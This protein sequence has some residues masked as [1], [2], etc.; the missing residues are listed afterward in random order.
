M[1]TSSFVVPS[2]R[3]DV[4]AM[5]MRSGCT[6]HHTAGSSLRM[7]VS[8]VPAHTADRSVFRHVWAGRTGCKAC[9]LDDE[10][11]REPAFDDQRSHERQ[12]K[13][14]KHGRMKVCGLVQLDVPADVEVAQERT[15]FVR[16]EKIKIPQACSA[17]RGPAA[18]RPSG[19]RDGFVD[20]VVCRPHPCPTRHV[21]RKRKERE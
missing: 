11:L 16:L 7:S 4:S 5:A 2:P 8:T 20:L 18:V 10:R 9:S 12:E 19:G 14:H 6:K 13:V 3:G 15:G 1:S 21:Q 17:R